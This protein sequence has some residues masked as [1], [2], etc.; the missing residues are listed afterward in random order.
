M[1]SAKHLEQMIFILKGLRNAVAHNGV[2]FD[3]RFKSGKVANGV[4]DLLHL[5]MKTKGIDFSSITDYAILIL[6]LMSKLGC[7]KTECRQFVNAYASTLERFR[8]D[9][10]YEIFGKI[11]RPD[12][13]KKLYSTN[14]YVKHLS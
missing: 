13:R 14:E 9:L 5:E 8:N 1:D 11:I 4:T 10:S 3:V 7:T 2:V 12:N 6:Y